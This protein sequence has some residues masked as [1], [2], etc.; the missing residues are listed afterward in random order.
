MKYAIIADIHANLE[1]LDVVL[2]DTRAQNCTHYACLGDVVGY[3]ANPKECLDIVRNMNI[4]VVK[5]NHDEYCSTDQPLDGFNPAAE[6]AVRSVRAT[7]WRGSPTPV[8]DRSTSFSG[9]RRWTHSS[10]PPPSTASSSH[11]T[12]LWR[13]CKGA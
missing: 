9:R 12:T 13:E 6:E 4:P 10:P 8:S 11:W 1:A 2:E 5:G 7:R 3:N